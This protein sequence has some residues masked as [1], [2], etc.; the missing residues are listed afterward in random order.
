MVAYV[1]AYAVAFLLTYV[2]A[3]DVAYAVPYTAAYMAA[4]DVAYAVTYEV[5]LIS[6]ELWSI[7]LKNSF[8]ATFLPCTMWHQNCKYFLHVFL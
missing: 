1:H 8:R 4:Y 7:R 6:E 3:F 5:A 2:V